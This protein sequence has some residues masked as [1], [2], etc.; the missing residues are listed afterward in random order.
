[1]IVARV[2]DEDKDKPCCECGLTL[3]RLKN[4]RINDLY[5]LSVGGN[6]MVICKDCLTSLYGKI[7]YTLGTNPF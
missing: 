5:Y 7:G 3:D 6:K 1:M 4:V 2:H